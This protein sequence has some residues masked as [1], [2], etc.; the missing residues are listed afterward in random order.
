VHGG[1]INLTLMMTC[2]MC[3]TIPL[4][5]VTPKV[6][7]FGEKRTMPDINESFIGICVT[8]KRYIQAKA[9]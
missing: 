1:I 2:L 4:T 5:H 9:Q 8:A 7:V 3:V 6:L